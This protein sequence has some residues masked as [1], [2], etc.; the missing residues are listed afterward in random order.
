[1]GV[2]G[3]PLLLSLW[4]T[5]VEWKQV[6]RRREQPGIGHFQAG[7]ENVRRPRSPEGFGKDFHARSIDHIAVIGD[8]LSQNGQWPGLAGEEAGGIVEQGAGDAYPS[9]PLATIGGGVDL[10]ALGIEQHGEMVLS[11]AHDVSGRRIERRHGND[12]APVDQLSV[13]ASVIPMRSPVK[14]PGPADT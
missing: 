13:L 2:E 7:G 9:I 12:L 10:L 14:L 3:F 4:A 8:A 6:A 5:D 11:G 1:M